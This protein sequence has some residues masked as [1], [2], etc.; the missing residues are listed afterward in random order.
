M[1]KQTCI[2]IIAGEASGDMHGARVVSALKKKRSN[3]VFCGIGG[4]ALKASGVDIGVDAST[5]AVVGITEVLKNAGS[6][7]NGLSTAKA[8]LKTRRPSLLV[9]IDF[10]D[11]NLRIARAAKKLGIPV[12]YYISPQIWAW[13]QGRVKKIKK[14]VDH[15]AVILPFETAFYDKAG[16]PATFVGHPLLDAGKAPVAGDAG[17]AD[18]SSPVIGLLP[19][20]R[21]GEVRRHL[22]VLLKAARIIGSRIPGSRFLLSAAASVDR[23][24]I[25]AILA[26][27]SG[28]LDLQVESGSVY[29]LFRQ[30]DLVIAASGTVTLEA[31]IS[32]VPMIA[33]YSI[34]FLSAWMARRL[35]QVK[36]VC[37]VNLIADRAVVPELLQKDAS[38]DGIAEKT[39]E[40]LTDPEKLQQMVSDLRD[41]RNRLGGPGA[42]EKV[43]DIA[44]EMIGDEGAI[45]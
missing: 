45:R 11:F 23:S 16:V 35:I 21:D 9:L 8:L 24:A 37:L 25:D 42:S 34:S 41:L 33:I 4:D 18:I 10:P 40:M 27:E 5:L 43:A 7:L 38:P 17:R 3:L 30:A 6:L 20:S 14:R 22:P 15:M 29:R 19:G 39:I 13:R 31:A 26:E 2:M 12:L 1:Y 44:L 32:G 28:G 36:Y